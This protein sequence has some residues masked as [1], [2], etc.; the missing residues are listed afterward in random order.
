MSIAAIGTA[1]V[2]A[3][4]SCV[5]E[6]MEFDSAMSQLAAT[7]GVTTDEIG[8]LRDVAQE[9]GATTAF[10]ATEAAEGL[11]ILAMAGLSAEEQTAVLG[12]VLN[13]AS[14]GA[15]SL[16]DAASY[17]TG[18]IKGFGSSMDDASYYAD[19]MAKG[20]TLA[21]TD[22]NGLGE[23]LSQSAATASS[24]GQT[25]D[26]V[27]LSLLKLAEQN[28]TGS[29]A[30]TALNR[31]MADLYTPTDS[32][33]T[34]LEELGVA[35][36]DESGAARDFNDIVDE[37]SGALAGMDDEQANA[38][39]STIFTTQGLSA[40]NKMCATS[41]D[42]T[43]EFK[44]ALADIGGSAA[45]Q[46][47]TQLDNL[48]GDITLFQSAVSGLKIAVSDGLTPALR[49]I[50]Q[51]G[52]GVVTGLTS[53]VEGITGLPETISGIASN[54][55]A[56]VE[57]EGWEGVGQEVKDAFISGVE[58]IL[59][60]I[61]EKVTEF[62][63]T[64]SENLENVDWGEVGRTVMGYILQGLKITIVD[65]PGAILEFAQQIIVS[66]GDVDWHQVGYNVMT[67]ILTGIKLIIVD[68]PT[69]L[70]EFAQAAITYLQDVDWLDVGK[71][72]LNGII[73]G[74]IWGVTE[75]IPRMVQGIIDFCSGIIDA[76][77]DFF[78]IHSPS[79]VME[80][81]G[82]YLVDGVINGKR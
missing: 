7:M 29:E 77:K 44:T 45:Q 46:A 28:V 36:Y 8:D 34:A 56:K 40:F 41:T 6:G 14:A 3:F 60:D 74:L 22:V 73:D 81:Q 63:N 12:D 10:S 42:K 70:F 20:A 18:T 54:L 76:F 67:A 25:A 79:T 9:M 55:K 57:E 69:A 72:I 15:L 16:E 23:A 53:I 30:A 80:E 27:T 2:A 38:Y 33:K 19:L 58:T 59:I 82:G 5:S 75:G 24:Y 71:T 37:L 48:A 4:K 43:D 61:P 65:I 1:V 51:V 31:A 64:V 26:S 32:A 68:V 52:T 39:K 11:N 13:L 17:V 62:F 49:G 35:C 78:G 50:V 66:L 21:N 47:E